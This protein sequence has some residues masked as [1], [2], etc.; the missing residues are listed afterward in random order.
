MTR[1]KKR[2][3]KKPARTLKKPGLPSGN[4][5]LD[6]LRTVDDVSLELDVRNTASGH[7]GVFSVIRLTQLA[8]VLGLSYQ[9]IWRW[10][11]DTQQLPAPVL[12]D[13]TT[14]R[15]FPVYHVEEARVIIEIVGNH[16]RQFKHYRKDHVGVRKQL[17]DKINALRLTTLSQNGEQHGDQKGRKVS[18]KKI[19]S[20]Q[21]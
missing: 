21:R 3:T 20:R 5:A 9:T 2:P 16:L 10:T 12:I 18:R 6:G 13:S 17:H 7:S 8:E 19:R 14:G 11:S 15:D 1:M 4:K